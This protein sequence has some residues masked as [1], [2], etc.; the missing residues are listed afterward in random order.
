VTP[1]VLTLQNVATT[2]AKFE[3]YPEFGIGGSLVAALLTGPIR[4]HFIS[5][6]WGRWLS[7]SGS[8]DW[9]TQKSFQI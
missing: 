6:I 2:C 4:N 5:R 9:A 7:G 1:L 3:Y 8:I